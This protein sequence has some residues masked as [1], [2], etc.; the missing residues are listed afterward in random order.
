MGDRRTSAWGADEHDTV[1]WLRRI[2]WQ[3]QRCTEP[4]EALVGTMSNHTG[5]IRMTVNIV[6]RLWGWGPQ[7]VRDS[8]APAPA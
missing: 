1:S 2:G 4:A 6:L 5:R 8:I 3:D 7:R